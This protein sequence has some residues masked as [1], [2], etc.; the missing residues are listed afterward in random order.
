M[1]R[2]INFLFKVIVILPLLFITST[3]SHKHKGLVKIKVNKEKEH[4][5][6]LLHTQQPILIEK[7]ESR[8]I[9]PMIMDKQKVVH[10]SSSS[11]NNSKVYFSHQATKV[12]AL[13]DSI[14]PN[15]SIPPP[16]EEK[17]PSNSRGTNAGLIV[18]VIGALVAIVGTVMV[19]AVQDSNS[20]N[21]TTIYNGCLG[22][23][24]LI[25]GVTTSLV[26]LILALVL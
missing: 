12:F 7:L 5:A 10:T 15:Q 18:F 11:I 24:L 14:K 9:F 2:R 23:I 8:K 21:S 1:Y 16:D 22:M 19:N 25:S 26:G 4:G 20:I 13:N 17:Q 3:C 6:V